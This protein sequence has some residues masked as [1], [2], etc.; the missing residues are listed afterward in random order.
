M[1]RPDYA[2]KL[3]ARDEAVFAMIAALDATL[4]PE[5]RGRLH[6]RIAGYAADVAFLKAAN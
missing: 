4:T 6:R 5:Q 3:R 2:A 1:R